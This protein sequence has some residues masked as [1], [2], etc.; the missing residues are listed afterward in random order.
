MK[1]SSVVAIIIFVGMLLFLTGCSKRYETIQE[2]VQDNATM[3]KH[4]FIDGVDV[5]G[6]GVADAWKA[7]TARH[8]QVLSSLRYEVKAGE[9]NQT[10]FASGLRISF[11]LNDVLLEALS[12]PF[13][14]FSDEKREYAC[15]LTVDRD[16]TK[17]LMCRCA[18][19]MYI[20][21][22]NAYAIYNESAEGYFD[23]IDAIQGLG[24][25]IDDL[26]D[27]VVAAAGDLMGGVIIPATYYIEAEYTVENARADTQLIAEY[28]TSFKGSTYSGTNRVFNITKAAGLVNGV[29]IAP[30]EEFNTNAIL[31][32]RNEKNGWEEATGIREGKYV[33]E[34][35]GG[36]CQLSGT[37]YNAA[38]MAEV[39]ITERQHHSWPLGYIPIGRDATISTGGPNLRFINDGEVPITVQAFVDSR[40]K[41]ITVRIYGRPRGDGLTVRLTSK[42]VETL[43]AP[44]NKYVL[45]S[46]LPLGTRSEQREARVGCIAETYKEY[47]DANGKVVKR[48]LVTKDKYKSIQGIINV[49]RDIYYQ[50]TSA[51][52]EFVVVYDDVEY[53][54]DTA[55]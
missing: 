25:D 36:V 55:G 39:N 21:P 9:K 42:K 29:T 37:L 10:I 14:Y 6:M 47:V 30:G 1:R 11:D 34:Y 52:V 51:D 15:K 22:Q 33:Q 8:K 50:Y 40:N 35:G 26:T 5:S 3:G 16:E 38:L 19:A 27:R 24:V 45:D 49:S 17:K 23:Y 4:V 32:S 31:G 7:V 44:G 41:T 2:A 13:S 12:A 28:T 43:D 20:A 18:D 54:D 46:S 48:E 53:L